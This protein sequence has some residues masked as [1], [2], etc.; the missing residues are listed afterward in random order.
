MSVASLKERQRRAEFRSDDLLAVVQLRTR[1][2]Q[3]LSPS[4][5]PRGHDPATPTSTSFLSYLLGAIAESSVKR[6]PVSPPCIYLNLFSSLCYHAAFFLAPHSSHSIIDLAPL[7]IRTNFRL[8]RWS[9]A[10]SSNDP[11]R[12]SRQLRESQNRAHLTHTMFFLL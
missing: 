12:H 7:S 3:A 1:G 5:S 6:Y 4:L 8:R 10:R 2:V 11:S 9:F